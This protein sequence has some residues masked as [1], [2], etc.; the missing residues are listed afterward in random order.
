MVFV[1]YIN[2]S[3]SNLTPKGITMF[4]MKTAKKKQ[5]PLKAS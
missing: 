4:F 1:V 5:P 2:G 3:G